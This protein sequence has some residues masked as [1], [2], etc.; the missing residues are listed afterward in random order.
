MDG[1]DGHFIELLDLLAFFGLTISRE[2]AV[3]EHFHNAH[4]P[5]S[6]DDREAA[7]FGFGLDLHELCGNLFALGEQH[8]TVAMRG[9][10]AID[11]GRAG[12]FEG[13]RLLG[14]GGLFVGDA[15]FFRAQHFLGPQGFGQIRTALIAFGDSQ[16]EECLEAE[17]EHWE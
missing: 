12:R 7:A 16:A 8:D 15:L 1:D 5:V 11:V 3:A 17:V 10:E 13:V 9:H 2:L 14:D 4:L 6:F